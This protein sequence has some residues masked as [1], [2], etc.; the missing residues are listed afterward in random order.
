MEEERPFPFPG[1]VTENPKAQNSPAS[2]SKPQEGLESVTSP[3][4]TFDPD[5][6]PHF[7]RL[8]E[9]FKIAREEFRSQSMDNNQMAKAARFLRDTSE[10]VMDFVRAKQPSAMAINDTSGHEPQG[11][12]QKLF[13]LRS[14]LDQAI[15]VA[16]TTC[17][18]R[19]RRFE[20]AITDVP[21][22]SQTQG[23]SQEN[24]R[25]SEA[26]VRPIHSKRQ[27]VPHAHDRGQREVL[28]GGKSPRTTGLQG[29]HREFRTSTG[30]PRRSDKYRPSYN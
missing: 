18:G 30:R 4:Q 24:V 3:A 29:I 13:E 15:E 22:K 19:K 9:L 20:Y 5:A 8:W 6:D 10:N 28:P 23:S 2:V 21:D 14:S 7:K 1:I 26:T 25:Q 16:E 11:L 17:G 12:A 27:R